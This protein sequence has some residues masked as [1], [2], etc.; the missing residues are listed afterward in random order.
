MDSPKPQA[1]R[2]QK[3]DKKKSKSKSKENASIAQ[4]GEPKE[5][6]NRKS[7]QRKEKETV[8]DRFLSQT[9]FQTRKGMD[10]T[11]ATQEGSLSH[12]LRIDKDPPE[13]GYSFK[14]QG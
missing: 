10:D 14:T 6:M 2:I 9:R 4:S 12:R 1:L 5:R 3:V 11:T 8:M 7:R 13:Y